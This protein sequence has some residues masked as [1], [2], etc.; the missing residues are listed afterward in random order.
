MGV[1]GTLSLGNAMAGKATLVGVGVGAFVAK[2]GSAT[3]EHAA[4]NALVALSKAS[5]NISRREN[6]IGSCMIFVSLAFK[7]TCPYYIYDSARWRGC[8]L[9][10]VLKKP[11]RF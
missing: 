4:S 11:G 7:V 9:K 1:M 10:N 8:M 6:L 5:R 2:S 3:R